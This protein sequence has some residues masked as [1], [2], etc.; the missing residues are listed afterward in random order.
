M[1]IPHYPYIERPKMCTLLTKD[2]GFVVRAVQKFSRIVFH[3]S[4]LAISD[5][6]NH[7]ALE[8]DIDF[9]PPLMTR[10]KAS[11]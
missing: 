6:V 9:A 1:I 11:V 7:L 3:T 5:S 8:S 4:M 10:D 2:Q